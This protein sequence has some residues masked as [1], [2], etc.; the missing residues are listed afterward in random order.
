MKVVGKD[1]ITYQEYTYIIVGACF[2]VGILALPNQLAEVS[3]QD[4]WIA[5]TIGGI[6]PFYIALLT[7]FIA[8][9]FPDDDILSISKKLFGN[10]FGS[11][12]NLLFSAHFFVNLIGITT[13]AMRLSI[14]YIVSFLSVFKIS[15]VVLILAVYGS[16]L[17]LKVIGRMNE[18]M[19]YLKIILIVIPLVALKDGS[20]LNV[21]P[22]FGSGIKNIFNGSVK[23]VFAYSGV[24][25][26]LLFYPN[27]KDK[28]PIKKAALKSVFVMIVIY[29]YVTFLTIYLAGPTI[30]TRSY[31]AVMLLNEAINLPFINSFRFFFMFIWIMIVFKTIITNYYSCSY[32]VS[33]FCKK[34]DIRKI[35]LIFFP[36]M[37]SVIN[38]IHDKVARREFLNKTINYTL[39]FNLIFVTTIA[40]IIYF[41]KGDKNENL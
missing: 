13:G 3:R 4:G 1:E 32:I 15:I 9:R 8:R 20:L 11:L 21:S 12:L 41:K 6:Y 16:L 31:F 38:I 7:S 23:S 28:V 17:G 33:N 35:C 39:L 27:I 18:L 24:E 10:F 5:A 40:I 25:V 34:L 14:L 19:Y 26:M 37:L 36:I 30:V 22:I 29:T 2:G